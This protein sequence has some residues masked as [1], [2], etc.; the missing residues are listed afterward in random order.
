MG[1]K[2][3]LFNPQT[4]TGEEYDEKSRQAMLDTIQFFE[5][6]GLKAIRE[7]DKNYVWQDD[8]MQYQKEHGIFA[9]MLTAEGYGDEDSRFDLYRLCPMSEILGFYGEA[10]QYPLQV[11]IL[12]VGPIWMSDNE[13]QKQELAQQLKDGHVF[14]FGM[15]EKEHGA[16]L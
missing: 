2:S 9:T 7:D 16:D 5:N 10:Y 8:W 14:A 13:F 6:K 12:G 11:S 3:V 15:S 1:K 4:F